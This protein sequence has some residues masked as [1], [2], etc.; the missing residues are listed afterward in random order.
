AFE[1]TFVAGAIKAIGPERVIYGSNL[2]VCYSDLAVESLRRQKLGKE[3]EDLLFGN[4]LARL[5]GL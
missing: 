2:P 5:L 3:V 1:P 4:N